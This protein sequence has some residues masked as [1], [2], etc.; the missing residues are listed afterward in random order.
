MLN[1]L[2]WKITPDSIPQYLQRGNLRNSTPAPVITDH[3]IQ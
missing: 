2:Q 1:E 3:E